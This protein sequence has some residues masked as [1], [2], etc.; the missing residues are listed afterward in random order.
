MLLILDGFLNRHQPEGLLMW[1]Q[2]T[3]LRIMTCM[4][5]ALHQGNNSHRDKWFGGRPG[6]ER[7]LQNAEKHAKTWFELRSNTD[8]S[9]MRPDESEAIKRLEPFIF[10]NWIQVVQEQAKEGYQNLQGRSSARKT[11]KNFSIHIKC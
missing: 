9:S 1:A 8:L 2:Y 4:S 10:L 11:L 7:A 3:Y 5:I 6:W